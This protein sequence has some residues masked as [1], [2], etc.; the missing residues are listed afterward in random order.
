MQQ[1]GQQKPRETQAS[2]ATRKDGVTKS[3]IAESH[4]SADSAVIRC[5]HVPWHP[6]CEFKSARKSWN[7]R[8]PWDQ[9]LLGDWK[10][11]PGSLSYISKKLNRLHLKRKKNYTA[12]GQ[13]NGIL[14]K[15][16]AFTTEVSRC[17]MVKVRYPLWFLPHCTSKWDLQSQEASTRFWAGRMDLSSIPLY[18][19][20]YRDS[21]LS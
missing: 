1:S 6:S 18:W 14:L 11:P 3:W 7:L 10:I 16:M 15:R 12:L 8:I 13:L 5:W 21:L 20:V 17:E 9:C 19:W 2:I 4:Q